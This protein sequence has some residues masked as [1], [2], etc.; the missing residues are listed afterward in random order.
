VE[1]VSRRFEAAPSTIVVGVEGPPV[2]FGTLKEV[3]VDDDGNIQ[4]GLTKQQTAVL[5]LATTAALRQ[6]PMEIAGELLRENLGV[7]AL[8][9]SRSILHCFHSS[10]SRFGRQSHSSVTLATRSFKKQSLQSQQCLQS[11]W[12]L[13]SKIVQTVS[14]ALHCR[15]M[16]SAPLYTLYFTLLPFYSSPFA[17]LLRLWCFLCCGGG[18]P[19]ILRLLAL[20]FVVV[21]QQEASRHPYNKKPS[22]HPQAHCGTPQ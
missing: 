7:F 17:S 14:S 4:E 13:W 22:R 9:S 1:V 21:L 6:H 3:V 5:L 20:S 2:K 18:V 12:S 10:D 15:R 16:M 11:L 19:F 8:L